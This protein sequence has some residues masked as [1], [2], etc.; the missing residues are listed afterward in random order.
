MLGSVAG[1]GEVA[2]TRRVFVSYSHDDRAWRD[3]FRQMLGPALARYGITLWADDHIRS[4][5]RWERVIDDA[6]D[7]T[8][9]GLLLVTPAYLM[10]PFSWEVEVPTL[11]AGGVPVVWVLVEDC[12]W[13][14]VEA[15]ARLQGLQ[16]PRRD[17]A[18]ADHP[19]PTRELARLCR[20]I[21]NEHLVGLRAAPAAA[22]GGSPPM[23]RPAAAG[24]ISPASPG[25]VFGAVPRRPPIFV[26]RDLD[27]DGLR[28]EV[29]SGLATAV[30]VTGTPSVFGLYGRGGIGKTVL[31]SEL[32]RDPQTLAWFPD[33]VFWVSL[34]ER[35]DVIG[36]QRE[37]VGWLGGDADAVRSP[38]QG[39][40]V[41]TELLAAKQCLL[42]AD[43]VW[44]LGAAQ[45]LAV[46]GPKGRLLLTTRDGL[47]PRRL[48]ATAI[49]LDV[50]SVAAAKRLL[51]TLVGMAPGELPVEADGIV[52][53][54]GRV[55]LAVALVGAAIGR[56][57]QSWSDVAA[58]LAEAGEM[59]A[60]HAYTNTFKALD[61]ATSGLAADEVDRYQ[62]LACFPEDTVVPPV[63]IGRLWG[64]AQPELS[65]QLRR[66]AELGL[67]RLEAGG[68]AFHDLQRDYLLLHAEAAALAHEQLLA[69]HRAS[70][71]DD[72]CR[73][74][75]DDPYLWDR[76]TYHLAAAGRHHELIATV[77]D[78]AW[79]AVRIAHGGSLAAERD[80][81]DALRWEPTE[82][83]LQALLRRLRQ[84]THLLDRAS[85]AESVVATLSTHLWPLRDTLDL[86]RL[87]RIAPGARL[88]VA[89]IADATSPQLVRTIT[90]HTGWVTSVAW[91]PDGA[92]LASAGDYDRMV[93]VWDTATG[94]Q[95]HALSGH[96]GGMR[97]VAWSPDATRLASA[98][99]DTT[100]RVWKAT[101]GT[102]LHTLSGHTGAV[103]SV[104]WSPDSTRLASA[105]SDTTVR[106]W[107][108]ATGTGLHT[109]TGHTGG[110]WS[111]AW[112][113]D[114][115]QLAS[116]SDDTTV[117]VWKAATGTQLHTL[118]GHTG[119]VNAVAWS[120][121]GTRLASA[122]RD[123]TVRVWDA[124]TGTGLHALTGHTGWVR[125][126][127]W[128]PDGTRLAS[129]S[130]DATVR[131]W[132][133]A[134]GTHLRTLSGH[135][136]R[137]WSVAWSPDGTQLASAS[138]DWTVRV[139][140]T[141]TGTQR[142]ARSAH[143]HRVRS[144]AW[145]PDGTRL[146]SASNDATV[147]VWDAATGTGLHALTGHTGEVRSVTW[148]PDS[149]QLASAG[150]DTTVRV[151]DAA[152]GT[153]LR[154]LSGHIG[155]V[156]SVAWA[157]DGTQLASAGD[158]A[159]VRVWDAATGAQLHTL[160]GH[161]GGV[162][163][164]AW[165]P[166]GTRLASAGDDATVRVWD[167]I[168]GAGLHT[169]SGHAG[170]VWSVA[171]S[172]DGTRLASASAD[173]TVRVWDAT[174]GAQLHT[175]S[176]H[177]G[178]VSSVAWAPDGT[179]LASADNDGAV[180]LRDALAGRRTGQVVA[181]QRVLSVDYSRASGALA[182]G[183]DRGIIVYNP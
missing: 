1:T 115:T 76:L 118:S 9:L 48:G 98:S 40:K 80:V 111:V 41:L 158:D 145:S 143:T 138:R 32:T 108:A 15:L 28:A 43:D 18:L 155:R 167:A 139:W 137:V 72:W 64:L 31:A 84:T 44:S 73:L 106:V 127:A 75:P 54:T 182:V 173:E 162:S 37:L 89:W 101:T 22:L 178:G 60:G 2:L 19:R 134:T 172:P 152:T 140:D 45:A 93:R 125:S 70:P 128:S 16:D 114:G 87:D 119:E 95:L 11:L 175:L 24:T 113:P 50:L 29:V 121:D 169:L 146:A 148:S 81:R 94:T 42:I 166:D 68:V 25:R 46:V 153:H 174:T 57:N 30:G 6:L 52:E 8:E 13:E 49:Q 157:P 65:V 82:P 183:T 181:S 99:D 144:L 91:S 56:G 3:A 150:D 67:V 86:A 100:V 164:V 10:S 53:A 85:G 149:T 160:S 78:P 132:D 154:T 112:S 38:L 79:L 159:T 171:W 135:I 51:G 12:L 90:G 124:A 5:Q 102:Q 156:W 36:A 61:V 33:G 63:T 47:L 35:A 17:G 77:T 20:R 88:D 110:V 109:L 177:T 39:A 131:V 117:R 83:R 71:G 96:T 107:D 66:F 163:S 14:D 34:G 62:A 105:S 126:V 58:R 129:T 179:R 122:S 7:G 168:T 165:A 69:A 59:F 136:G 123:R 97:S 103:M 130:S 92:Q 151:W 21:R 74:D 161:T 26:G 142:D 27:L 141:A 176:G 55:A 104:A 23:V 147:R 116:A 120:P 4:G 170:G 133:A 180:M